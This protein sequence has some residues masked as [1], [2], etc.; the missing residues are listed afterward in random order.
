MDF[1]IE[2]LGYDFMLRGLTGGLLAA[3]ACAILS[4]FVVWRGMSFMGD[5]LAHSVLPGI[6]FAYWAGFSLLWGALGA[7][8]LVV[9]GIGWASRKE[10]LRE[11]A[12]IGVV[13][14]GFFALGILM[15]SK[16]A[17][18]A[19]L[20]HILFGNILGVSKQ[21]LIF[22][23]IVT[24][25]VVL[26]TVL[27]F[28]EL[29]AASFDPSHARAIGLSPSLVRFI[30]LGLLALTTVVALRTV[31]VVLVLALLVTPGAPASMVSKRLWGIMAL[32]VSLAFLSTILGFYAS[33]YADVPSGPAIVLAL[34]LFFLFFSGI[35]QIQK[36]RRQ[37]RS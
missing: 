1:L 7:A 29:V 2:P 14:A 18:A 8:V 22:M 6:V 25:F 28:K 26:A 27:T 9:A 33:Y 20:G 34:T 17:T 3:T 4:A 23:A 37:R 35:G 10:G 15:L 36:H 31:G 30:L 19:D 21:D 16:V 12:A 32:S 5:A 13:F 24:V 11:D